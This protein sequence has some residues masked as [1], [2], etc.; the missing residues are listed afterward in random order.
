MAVG[1][2]LFRRIA[3]IDAPEAACDSETCRWQSEAA[4]GRRTRHPVELLAAA[5]R[6][7]DAG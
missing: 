7:F 6:S 1:E 2:P 4:T 5:Y 3:E